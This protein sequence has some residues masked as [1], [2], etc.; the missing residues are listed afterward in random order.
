M[1][2][3]VPKYSDSWKKNICTAKSASHFIY[4]QKQYE[5]LA[6]ELNKQGVGNK[7]STHVIKKNYSCI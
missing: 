4:A 1:S 7:D 2:H 5:K 3:V 6:T